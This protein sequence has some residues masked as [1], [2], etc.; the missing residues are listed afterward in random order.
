MRNTQPSSSAGSA[1]TK[2]AAAAS[3]MAISRFFTKRIRRVFS[4]LS[5]SCPAVAENSRNGR[6][7]SAPMTSPARLG[8]IHATPSW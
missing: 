6:M 4:S 7:N 3:M 1:S 2:P 5:V 8:G